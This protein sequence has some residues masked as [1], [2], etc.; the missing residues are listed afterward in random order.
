MK[1]TSSKVTVAP[2]EQG[3]A[4]RVSKNNPEYGHVRIV[5]NSVQFNAQGW[6]NKKQ[7]STLIHG[8][9]ED[10][11]DL[12]FKA[13]MELDGNIIVREQLTAFNQNDPSR[14]LKIAGE[15]GIVCKGVDQETGEVK[16]IYRKSFYDPTG[17]QKSNIIPH[18]NGDEIR[19]ANGTET[20]SKKKTLSQSELNNILDKN[21]KPKKEEKVE[22]K[23]EEEVIMEEETF[24]L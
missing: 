16:E 6:V 2:D 23:V 9:V 12:E 10:L 20:K 11:N 24:E 5:Q 21:K 19:E 8:T 1:Q 18:I 22:E 13:N 3:N 15:T 14:D 7:L 4:I 17:L